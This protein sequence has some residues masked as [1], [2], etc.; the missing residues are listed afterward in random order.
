MSALALKHLHMTAVAVS[1]LL[2]F[3]RGIWMMR[4]SPL[5]ARRWVKVLPHVNDTVLLAAGLAT[6]YRV[7]QYPFVDDWLTAKVFGLIAYIVLGTLA[8]KRARTKRA[9]IA[10]WVAALATFGYVV[11]VAVT[12]NPIP[13]VPL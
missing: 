4:E 6:A 10:Y 8:L 9:R 12:K 2:F 11:A 5:I 3:I 1:F 7:G 13:F